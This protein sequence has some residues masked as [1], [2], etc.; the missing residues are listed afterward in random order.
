[1][2]ESFFFLRRGVNL[3]IYV[4]WL[5]ERLSLSVNGISSWCCNK[6]M[7]L[8]VEDFQSKFEDKF[9]TLIL[10]WQKTFATSA[11]TFSYLL[12]LLFQISFNGTLCTLFFKQIFFNNRNSSPLKY[13]SRNLKKGI[14]NTVLL[15]NN[16][17]CPH[18][19]THQRTAHT[20]CVTDLRLCHKQLLRGG[21]GNGESNE[22]ILKYDNTRAKPLWTY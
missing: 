19:Q 15:I 18:W 12:T 8:L 11:L 17:D 10:F 13:R 2:L 3:F 1:M 9:K 20:P 22:N 16:Y 7:L 5:I 14:S 6:L 21:G 4:A